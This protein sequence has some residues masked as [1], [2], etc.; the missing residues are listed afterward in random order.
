M[1]NRNYIGAAALLAVIATTLTAIAG[2]APNRGGARQA[3][4]M[5]RPA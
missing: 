2:T 5:G 1:R 4:G 3:T